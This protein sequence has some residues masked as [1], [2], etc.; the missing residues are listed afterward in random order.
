MFIPQTYAVAL[1]MMV[2]S[3]L[4]WGSWANTQKLARNWRFELLVFNLAPRS[5]GQVALRGRDPRLP[6]RIDLRLLTDRS[7]HDVAVLLEGVRLAQRIAREAPIGRGIAR[8]LS[9]GTSVNDDAALRQ[10]IRRS[11]TD[12]AHP[13]GTCAPGP[14]DDLRAVVGADGRVHGLDNVFVADASVMREIPRA[15]TNFACFLIGWHAGR[16]LAAE[17]V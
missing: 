15:N 5:R 14:A 8:E 12:Y 13:V 9:P 3:M 10:L 11:V 4:C 17:P 1:V 6:P 7:G 16:R 2:L